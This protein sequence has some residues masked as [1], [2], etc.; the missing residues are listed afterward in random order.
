MIITD[1]MVERGARAGWNRLEYQYYGKVRTPWEQVPE[2]MRNRYREEVYAILE[3]ALGG[4]QD[5]D[6]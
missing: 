1:E 2:R 5:A 3:A 6:R 4:E